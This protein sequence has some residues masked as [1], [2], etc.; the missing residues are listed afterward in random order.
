MR[1]ILGVGMVEYA[2]MTNEETKR[3]FIRE[4]IASDL[5][6][7]HCKTPITRFP[8]E[9]NGYLHIGHAKAICLDFGVAKNTPNKARCA[10]CVSMTRTPAR[11][12]SSSS[13]PYKKTSN[14]WVLTGASTCTG[15]PTSLIFTMSVPCT[16]LRTA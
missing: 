2:R 7:G 1:L 4:W 14:G 5:A 10:T 12:M 6:E 16:S 15:H 11:K 3:D 9:P 13:I 8:P